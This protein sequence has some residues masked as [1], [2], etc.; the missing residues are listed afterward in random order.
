MKYI[1][2]LIEGNQDDFNQQIIDSIKERISLKID[3][4]VDEI[5][6]DMFMDTILE[7]DLE[8]Y[9]LYLESEGIEYEIDGDMIIEASSAIVK[10]NKAGSGQKGGKLTRVIKPCPKGESRVGKRGCRKGVKGS[11]KKSNRKASKTKKRQVSRTSSGES[12]KRNI[13][14][15]KKKSKKTR[16]FNK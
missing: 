3:E 13:A 8:D 11:K 16:R 15:G 12:K 14:I 2:S 1:N 5:R 6:D 10:R 4:R 7:E 9:I